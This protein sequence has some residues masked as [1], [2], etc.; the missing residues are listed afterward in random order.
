[1]AG[2]KVHI[3]HRF[4]GEDGSEMIGLVAMFG[5]YD[6]VFDTT[7]FQNLEGREV[8]SEIMLGEEV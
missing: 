7:H 1:L 2:L 8:L 6:L 4:A 5:M 3:A